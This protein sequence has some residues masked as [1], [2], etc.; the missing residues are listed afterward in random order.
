MKKINELKAG[1]ILSYVNLGISCVIPLLYT[2]IM[3]ELLG[4]AEYGIYSLS[5]SVIS[6]L[7]L[8]NFGMGS[9]VSRYVV[10]CRA[11]NDK[12]GVERVTGLFTLI[13]MALAVLVCIVGFLLT[14]SADRFFSKGLTG[15]EIDRLKIL[16]VIMTVST[17]VSFPVSVFSSICVAYE[18]YVFRRF[19]DIAT[20]IASPILN[21][22]ILYAGGKSIGMALVG[23]AMQLIYVPVFVGYCIKRLDIHP[24]FKGFPKGLL[25]EIWSFSA[26]VFFSM[27]VDLLYWSTDKLL[28]GALVGSVAVAVYN[29]GNVFTNMLQNMSSSISSVFAP[30]V[31]TLVVLRNDPKEIS[32]LLVRVGR[33][34][35]LIVAFVLSGYI[36]FGQQFIHFWAGDEYRGAYWV[37][38]MTMIPLSIPLIQNIAYN[39]I[40]AQRKHQFRAV[41]Y[42]IIAVLNVVSTYIVL[43]IYGIVG[44]AVCTG[45][46]FVLGNG[47]I[48]NIYYYRVTK[49]DIPLFWKNIGKMSV[50]SI[51]LVALSYPIVNFV[52]PYQS[53]GLFLA[54]V[55]AFSAV[56]LTA[57]WFITMND[58]ERDIFGGMFTKLFRAVFRKG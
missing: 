40:L 53:I 45:I 21:L 26:F 1:A 49:L 36:V 10:K 16:L 3:L 32:S 48:M 54:E 6:Y 31:T 29:V 37:A 11:E 47:I 23:F 55:A 17:A 58:Y 43:P 30:R 20:T 14:F 44:A 4:Q 15:A 2:P 57:T 25:R 13:Y 18:R 41:V 56:Y 24:K 33:I 50:V 52:I 27:I 34:Q 12:D 28:I 22:I 5:N 9:A 42:A 7:S 8:L 35:Y 39:T 19:W 38:L 46:A 51:A